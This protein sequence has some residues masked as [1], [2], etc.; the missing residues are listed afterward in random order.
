M[1]VKETTIEL[2]VSKGLI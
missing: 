2:F 1:S